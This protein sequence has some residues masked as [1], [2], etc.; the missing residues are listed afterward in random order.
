MAAAN[1]YH[2]GK[3]GYGF[4]FSEIDRY[5]NGKFP[6]RSRGLEKSRKQANHNYD[7]INSFIELAKAT[8]AKAVLVANPFVTKDD[9]IILIIKE[10]YA[11]N[12]EIIGRNRSSKKYY[13]R[14]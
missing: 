3:N 5:H 11:N 1:F 9:D 13:L 7:Y 10:L 4:D 2:F 12:I 14:F 8:N 6:K